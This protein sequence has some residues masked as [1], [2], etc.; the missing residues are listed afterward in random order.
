MLSDLD[1]EFIYKGKDFF[2]KEINKVDRD[3]ICSIE[4]IIVYFYKDKDNIKKLVRYN[5]TDVRTVD[6]KNM[7]IVS[8]YYIRKLSYNLELYLGS[9]YDTIISVY[10]VGDF[11]IIADYVEKKED[12]KSKEMF[13][14]YDKEYSNMH[15]PFTDEEFL[16]D[17]YKVWVRER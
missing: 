10:G 15:F 6:F 3:G 1:Y 4:P 7:E 14:K 9:E 13:E 17:N 16:K 11:R 2:D 5:D 8:K 12:L